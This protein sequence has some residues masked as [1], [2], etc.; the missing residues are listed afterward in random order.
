MLNEHFYWPN[1]RKDVEKICAKCIACKQAKS[2]SMPHG[3]YTPLPV[4][5]EPWTDISMDFVLG[6]MLRAIV[7][8]NLK[9]SEDY[10]PFIDFAYNR[11][12]HSSTDGKKKVE[13]VK[14]IHEKAREHIEKKNR[15]YAEKAN[16]GRKQDQLQDQEL[17]SSRNH[18]KFMWENYWSIWRIKTPSRHK[19]SY[20]L[21]WVSMLPTSPI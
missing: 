7:G 8:K 9:T 2:K 12:V 15:I 13:V 21:N 18:S 20:I 17:R 19:R 3:L 6:T 16:K 1:K 14:A 5:T 4:P 11:V 10:L